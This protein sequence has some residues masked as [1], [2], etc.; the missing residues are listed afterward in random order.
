VLWR[1]ASAVRRAR[2]A[3]ADEEA[4]WGEGGGAPWLADAAAA[5]AREP[6]ELAGEEDCGAAAKPADEGEAGTARDGGFRQWYIENFTEVPLCPPPHP[7]L[8]PRGGGALCA[9]RSAAGGIRGR[10]G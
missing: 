8:P 3:A 1:R 4:G 9:V 2:L 5:L 7:P 10:A 6:A